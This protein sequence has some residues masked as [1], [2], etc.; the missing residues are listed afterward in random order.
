MPE[1][2]ERLAGAVWGHLVGDAVG[3]PYEFHTP[4]TI[5]AVV[6]GARGSHHQPAG[7]WSDDGALMLA[8]LDSLLRPRGPRDQRFDP[9]DQGARF[10]AWADRRACTPDGDGPFDVGGATG[11][12]LDR[13]RRGT[14]AELAGGTDDHD[15]GNGSLM[16]I[17]PLALV[18][19]DVSDDVLVD[20][21]RRSSSITHGH[22][23]SQTTCALYSLVARRLLEGS[24]PAAALDDATSTLRQVH[25]DGIDPDTWDRALD[26]IE[27]WRTRAGRTYVIDAFWSAWDA[28]AEADSYPE[29]IER[30]IRYGNDTDTTACIAGGLAGIRWGIEGIPQAWLAGMRGQAIV[31]P[32]VAALVATTEGEHA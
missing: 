24:E 22:P 13:L 5:G 11:A 14:P 6:F 20:H 8:S 30:A 26:A 9:T 1:L 4:D 2:P 19:R 32:L 16:R 28:F 17:L 3:V 31:E 12:A 7:T 23:I 18:E 21:A 25:T 29:A 27:G 15:N 10:L